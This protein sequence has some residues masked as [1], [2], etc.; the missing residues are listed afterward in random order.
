MSFKNRHWYLYKKKPY[1]LIRDNKYVH[2]MSGNEREYPDRMFTHEEVAELYKNYDLAYIEPEK[3]CFEDSNTFIYTGPYR[4]SAF[5]ELYSPNDIVQIKSYE[6][7]FGRLVYTISKPGY[8]NNVASPF[9][10]IKI[11]I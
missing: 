5:D 1:F 6:P 7:D 2:F 9:E 4:Y 3:Y 10:L 11:N 8:K